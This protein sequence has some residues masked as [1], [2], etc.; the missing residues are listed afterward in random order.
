MY[1]DAEANSDPRTRLA[2]GLSKIGLVLRHQAWKVAESSGLTPTQSQILAAIA[3]SPEGWLSVSDVAR[4]LAVTQPTASDAIAA[5]ERKRLIERTRADSDARVVQVRI[6][7]A[8]RRRARETA[9]WPDALLVAIGELDAYEQGVFLK[10]M[11]KMIRSLQESGQISTSRMCA[12]CTHF[13]PH[14]HPGAA[15]PHHCAFVDA[16][17][18]DNDL[19]LDCQDHEQAGEAERPRLWQLFI[20]GALPGET[21]SPGASLGSMATRQG[22][23]S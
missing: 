18:R 9:E 17:L 4:H 2:T 1:K 12:T 14:A 23:P 6:T 10:A 22:D 3:H 7:G 13:R 21:V 5:L 16:P 8:G 19:R 11:T 15:T 20:K